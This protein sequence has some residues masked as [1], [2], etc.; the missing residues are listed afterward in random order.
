MREEYYGKSQKAGVLCT[1]FYYTGAF[2]LLRCCSLLLLSCSIFF[3]FSRFYFIGVSG[4]KGRIGIGMAPRKIQAARP[5]Q[6]VHPLSWTLDPA[7]LLE[8]TLVKGASQKASFAMQRS[9]YI[10]KW[11]LLDIRARGIFSCSFIFCYVLLFLISFFKRRGA[12]LQDITD[13]L[14]PCF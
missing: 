10:Q 6:G 7:W 3:S 12:L 8:V 2:G 11:S 9:G 1:F 4:G 5:T 14:P 13:F